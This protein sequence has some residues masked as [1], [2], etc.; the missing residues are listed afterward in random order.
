[1]RQSPARYRPMAQRWTHIPGLPI[2][3][4][5][6]QPPAHHNT[7]SEHSATMCFVPGVGAPKTTRSAGRRAGQSR[8]S[9]LGWYGWRRLT[10]VH[11][12]CRVQSPSASVVF[13]I[14]VAEGDLSFVDR[15]LTGMIELWCI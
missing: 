9:S 1:M 4:M 5:A 10:L 15:R 8:V 13:S 6:M 7:T 11:L 14:R 3:I 12:P 2:A